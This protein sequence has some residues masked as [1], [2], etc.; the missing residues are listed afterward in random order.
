M[1]FFRE[2]N[3]TQPQI[4]RV[5]E[6]WIRDNKDKI[7][8]Y[9]GAYGNKSTEEYDDTSDDRKYAIDTLAV[10][11]NLILE[12]S[13][14]L[15]HIHK[16][17]PFKRATLFSMVPNSAIHLHTDPLR[18]VALNM[19]I[20]GY[21]S[22]SLF[23]N[24]RN[25]KE[26]VYKP[27][28]F[29]VIDTSVPHMVLNYTEHRYVLTLQPENI[30]DKIEYVDTQQISKPPFLRETDILRPNYSDMVEFLNSKNCLV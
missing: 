15:K 24:G 20:D 26:L 7:S 12:S 19:L 21:N 30:G 18:N 29:Y 11:L 8:V 1:D 17:F 27:N 2:T 16:K 10:P 22:N 3:I 23:F 14:L 4:T 5:C 28:T 6:K 25:F 9:D 13:L